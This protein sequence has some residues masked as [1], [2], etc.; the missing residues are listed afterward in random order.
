MIMQATL[1]EEHASAKQKLGG[2]FLTFRL[3]NE[4]YGPEI[5]LDIDK[6]LTDGQVMNVRAI[7]T[8]V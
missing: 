7:G 4:E 2:R 8:A 1:M 6:V 5:L 3:A